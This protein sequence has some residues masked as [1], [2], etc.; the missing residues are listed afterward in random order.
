[1][2]AK[3]TRQLKF[4]RQGGK[5]AGEK[6]VATENDA[7]VTEKKQTKKILDR[8]AQDL[9]NLHK[10]CALQEEAE[11]GKDKEEER[12]FGRRKYRPQ[13]SARVSK[14]VQIRGVSNT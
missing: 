8:I 6:K 3:Q 2:E 12:L 5:E 13:P 14:T 11:E 4:G 1:M 9:K 7:T 10:H